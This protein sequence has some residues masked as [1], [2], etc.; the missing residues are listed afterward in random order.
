MISPGTCNLHQIF[1]IVPILIVW[2]VPLTIEIVHVLEIKMNTLGQ[3]I[4]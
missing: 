2:D 4:D 3:A 1:N